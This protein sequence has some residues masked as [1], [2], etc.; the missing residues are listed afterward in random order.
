MKDGIK[1][2]QPRLVHITIRIIKM[3]I[4]IFKGIL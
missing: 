2:I 3:Y 1:H 4:L